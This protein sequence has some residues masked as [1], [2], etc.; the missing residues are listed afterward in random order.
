MSPSQ[1]YQGQKE[2]M[3]KKIIIIGIAILM[4]LL[5]IFLIALNFI[6]T[7]TEKKQQNII[8]GQFSSIKEILEHY[9]CKY[10]G[11]KNSELDEFEIDIYTIFKCNLYDGED[12]NEKF[13]NNVINEIAKFVNYTN[14]RIIDEDK[15]E[16]IEIQ[17]LCNNGKIEKI[18]INGIEDY[19]IYMD[20]QI[21]LSKYKELKTTDILVQ[22]QEV[23]NCIQNNWN[24]N[25]VFGSRESIF[26]NYYIYFDE[27]IKT[28]K[29]NGKIYN[30]IFTDKYKNP[31][32][33]GLN[34]GM[35]N[36]DVISKLGEPTFKN[37]DM[38]VI[39]YKSKDIYVFFEKNQISIYRNTKEE[40]FDEFFELVDEFLDEKYSLLEFMNELTY[41][42]PDY[43]EYTY[44]AETVFLSYPNKGVDIKINYDNMDGIILYNNIGVNQKI[45]NKYLEHTE[46]LAQ[47][48]VDNVFKAEERRFNNE[49]NLNTKCKEYKEEF[50]KEDKG[51]RGEIYDYYMKMSEN[52]SIMCTYFIAKNAEFPNCELNENINSYIWI[53]DYCFAYSIRSKGIYYYDLKNQVKGTIITG[54]DEY[55]IESYENGILKYDEKEIQIQY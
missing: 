33:N 50:E 24:S 38:S 27:G 21:S 54:D 22:A 7:K 35:D 6:N 40:G 53:N 48:Q 16:Q 11:E 8:S 15:E 30:I 37:D 43:D 25:I 9:G 18:L 10:K 45:V 2:I 4:V 44:D 42:W 49:E 3:L 12:S 23:I 26:Q 51:N 19:F 55:K 52:N 36:R 17:V 31:V 47:L 5:C 32:V 39:G 28:R 13:Y 46:F 14:F 41:L 1:R 29:I 20:S 34:V